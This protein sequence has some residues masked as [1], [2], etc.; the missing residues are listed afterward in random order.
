[1]AVWNL[2][3]WRLAAGR[4]VKGL[5]ECAGQQEHFEGTYLGNQ[6][7]RLTKSIFSTP[8]WRNKYMKSRPPYVPPVGLRSLKAKM[9][10]ILAMRILPVH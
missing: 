10:N 7:E 8:P 6:K 9:D 1:M 3:W 4:E 2:E 5:K